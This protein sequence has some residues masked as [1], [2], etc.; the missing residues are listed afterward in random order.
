MRISQINAVYGYG[1]TGII[2]RD[3]QSLC[4]QAGLDCEVVYSKSQG[5]VEN[6]FQIGNAFSDKL[7]A[8]LTRISGKQGYFSW[9]PTMRLL[10][11]YDEC[12]PDII[13][14]HN[15]HGSYINLPML[16]RYAAKNDI[17]VV[18]TLHDC[19]FYTGGCSH[20]THSNCFRWKESCGNCPQRNWEFRSLIYDASSTKLNDRERL[21]GSIRNLTAVGVSQWIVDEAS[22]K[23]FRNARRV[24]IHN[25]IDTDFFHPVDSEFRKKFN[26]DGKF[27]ILAPA[28]KWFLDINRQTFEYFARHLTDDM[29]MV[30]IGKDVDTSRL[31]DKML[32]IGFVSSRKQIRAI[33]SACDVM[34][35][36]S[37]EESLS[38]LNIEVQSCGTP[39]VTYANTGVRETVDN[40]CSF[41]VEN[42][43]PQAAWNAMMKIREKGKAN[44]SAS[45]QQ[46]A[47]QEFD[48]NKN[49]KKYID[50]YRQIT[51]NCP[52]SL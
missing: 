40:K 29:R 48:A 4:R 50:L 9:M 7:H 49:Y 10:R 24:T 46:W 19:W 37:R 34:V 51:D 47:R 41:A 38:L 33:Y 23:V 6:G 21:F 36:C 8:L 16:L 42:G 25:G 52:G 27:V 20:Y 2:V 43:N 22:Y 5:V 28:N 39:V 30:F 13:H 45:C 35:N 31:T 44:L 1:S 3:L 15:L 32:N 26:L 14:L 18:V 17:P 11:H 12:K